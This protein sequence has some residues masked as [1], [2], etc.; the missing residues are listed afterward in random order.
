MS[1]MVMSGEIYGGGQMFGYG[2][3]ASVAWRSI[4]RRSRRIH[5]V[6]IVS[7]GPR[8]SRN[9]VGCLSESIITSSAHTA[10]GVSSWCQAI[11]L[12][13]HSHFNRRSTLT[14][15]AWSANQQN[16]FGFH[17]VMVPDQGDHL[18]G[19]PNRDTI[20]K[21]LIAFIICLEILHLCNMPQSTIYV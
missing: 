6:P 5:F 1:A 2:R 8:V 7:T 19:D 12:L 3:T 18:L 15:P 11:Y 20:K 14:M 13:I 9:W 21:L 4:S 16:G 17:H 10:R